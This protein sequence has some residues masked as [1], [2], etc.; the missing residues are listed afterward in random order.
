MISAL[1]DK[2]NNQNI[3]FCESQIYHL[4]NNDISREYDDKKNFGPCQFL[5]I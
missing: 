3:T 5:N 1:Y 2:Q 4:S